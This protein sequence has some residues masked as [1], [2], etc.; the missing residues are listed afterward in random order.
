MRQQGISRNLLKQIKFSGGRICVD[1]QR[2]RVTYKMH[3]GQ[4][5]EVTLPPEI[6][7]DHIQVSNTPLEILYE[8]AHF[9]VVNKPAEVASVP[10]H[11]YADDSLVNRVK[12]YLIRTHAASQ[13]THIVT[14]LDRETSGIVIFAKHHFAH[15]V[16]DT[17]LKQHSLK[18]TYFCVVS[19]VLKVKHAVI[20][21][22]IGREPGSFIKRMVRADG[23]TAQTEYWVAKRMPATTLLRI[24]LHTGRTHQIRVHM[25]SIGHPL[26]G[27]FL[28]GQQTNPWIHR[29]ALHCASVSFYNPFVQKQITCYAPMPADLATLIKHESQ[30]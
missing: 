14:R 4:R 13:V 6:P 20:D 29:Q 8:D 26:V 10:S 21:A 19:G 7:S 17:Q 22:P 12:G 15:T 2:V 18:K 25:A 23:R 28:Y 5:L 30:L 27:D 9:L 16:L 24:R 1:G 3:S 11:I